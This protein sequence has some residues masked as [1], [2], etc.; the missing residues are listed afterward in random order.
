MSLFLFIGKDLEK[1][2]LHYLLGTVKKRES[3]QLIKHHNNLQV[4]PMTPVD[5]LTFCEVKIF[6]FVMMYIMH[7]NHISLLIQTRCLYHWKKQHH[8]RGTHFFAGSNSS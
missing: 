1:F 7:N 5:Q 6:M 4:I 2:I 8:D 3:K